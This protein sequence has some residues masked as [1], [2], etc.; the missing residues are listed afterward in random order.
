[1][2][3]PPTALL[4]RIEN[5]DPRSLG[6]EH[7]NLMRSHLHGDKGTLG[8]EE[9]TPLSV[10]KVSTVWSNIV[11]WLWLV[12]EIEAIRLRMPGTRLDQKLAEA[13][14]R[15]DAKKG[16]DAE[17]KKR[18]ATAPMAAGAGALQASAPAGAADL[19]AEAAAKSAAAATDVSAAAGEGG[20]AAA[21]V[22][23]RSQKE[24]FGRVAKRQGWNS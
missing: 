14:Q 4:E 6:M 5:Y 17:A 21:T 13:K 9:V 23:F 11:R 15:A 8:R 7:I 12:I 16:Q 20:T 10:A 22:R 2:L 1:M 18:R 19:G 24:A 3:S